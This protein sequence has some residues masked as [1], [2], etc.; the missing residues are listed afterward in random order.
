[1]GFEEHEAVLSG[2]RSGSGFMGFD[3]GSGSG[4][5]Y[6]IDVMS[7]DD[8][9]LFCSCHEDD[10]ISKMHHEFER[11]KQMP[12]MN[13]QVAQFNSKKHMVNEVIYMTFCFAV[14]VFTDLSIS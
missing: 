7:H 2:L 1:M 9:W 12:K 13:P 6:P 11:T 10:D 14:H 5:V 8:R 4:P 3:L